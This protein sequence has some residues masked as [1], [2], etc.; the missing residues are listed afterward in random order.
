[1]I[2]C[3]P[4]PSISGYLY[5]K[6]GRQRSQFGLNN[7]AGALSCQVSPLR[8]R[9]VCPGVIWCHDVISYVT[10]C[11][12]LT[13]HHL[14]T[15]VPMASSVEPNCQWKFDIQTRFS[16]NEQFWVNLWLLWLFFLRNRRSLTFRFNYPGIQWMWHWAES[17]SSK[18]WFTAAR[19]GPGLTTS[20]LKY[21]NPFPEPQLTF[22]WPH[23]PSPLIQAS[24]WSRLITW[25][26]YWPLI[27]QPTCHP[28]IS[29]WFASPGVPARLESRWSV[30]SRI[31]MFMIL[32]ILVKL[33][34]GLLAQ[35]SDR[36]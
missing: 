21:L 9:R 34:D 18:N 10:G 15:I 33:S 17:C 25:P 11:H 13:C 7:T 19:P 1:M 36:D 6:G 35:A 8:G 22:L 24:D 32:L 23:K 31:F 27:G 3:S 30:I 29:P 20:Q 12:C 2:A 14:M 16:K 26:E 5:H 28:I 4:F